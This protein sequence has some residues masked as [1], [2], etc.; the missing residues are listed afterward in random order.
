MKQSVNPVVA[1][2]VVVLIVGVVGFF[3][4]K[5]TGGGNGN[6]SP[7]QVGNASPFGPGGE[8]NKAMSNTGKPRTSSPPS[9]P[10]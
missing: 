9:A 8:A 1:T 2:V 4:W 10:R 5:G 3:L 6:K 7:G